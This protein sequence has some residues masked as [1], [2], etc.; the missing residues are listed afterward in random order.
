MKHRHHISLVL[1][2]LPV[3]AALLS[4]CK[5]EPAEKLAQAVLPAE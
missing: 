3:L 5:G 2:V 1:T 4:G